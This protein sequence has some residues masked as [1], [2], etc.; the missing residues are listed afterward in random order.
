MYDCIA[1][2][3]SYTLRKKKIWLPIVTSMSLTS[4][5][6]IRVTGYFNLVHFIVVSTYSTYS[7]SIIRKISNLLSRHKD[8]KSEKKI[9]I[10]NWKT[11]KWEVQYQHAL[12]AE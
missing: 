3:V 6:D 4:A 9:D 11:Y 2:A 10:Y 8:E 1:Y 7:K 12:V 5:N